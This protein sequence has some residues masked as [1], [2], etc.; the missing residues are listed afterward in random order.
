MT[1][2]FEPNPIVL[3]VAALIPVVLALVWY[4]TN[5]FGQALARETKTGVPA[6]GVVQALGS[7][8]LAFLTAF[9]LLSY[10]NHQMSVM[11][12]FFSRAGFGEEGTEA[13]L[14]F[15]QVARLVGDMHLSFGHGA[16]HGMMGAV[17]FLLP[18]IVTVAFRERQS[19]KY[20]MI[21][22]GY[23]LLSWVLMGGV[24]CEWGLKVNL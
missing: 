18:V 9:G 24:L 5:V 10:V 3:P 7:Y 19:F 20:I 2:L 22:F 23:W 14:A 16:A 12:L 4:N 21:H 6:F 13:T 11:Q 8:V 17:V 15:E 1:M